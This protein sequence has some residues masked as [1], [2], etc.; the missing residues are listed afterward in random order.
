M[1]RNYLFTS[2]SVSEGHPD[3]MSDQISDAILDELIKQDPKSRV[4]CETLVTTNLM[5]VAGE[6]TTNAM[7][8]YAQM[9]Y[10]RFGFPAPPS[11][12]TLRRRFLALPA[13]LQGF[14]PELASEVG[15]LDERFSFRTAFADKS[16]FRGR[17]LA[18]KASQAR[19]RAASLDGHRGPLIALSRLAFRLWLAWGCQ[20]LS[21]DGL[22]HHRQCQGL[23]ST[24]RF[25][26]SD[27]RGVSAG[28]R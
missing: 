12:K 6:V 21:G 5:V 26:P 17:P 11:R 8:D 18:P 14:M 20:R 23:P 7:A 19:H 28:D 25:A 3:K 9:H 27:S 16:I 15:G 10:R 13:F 22:C 1:A 24:P 4:A 2:E